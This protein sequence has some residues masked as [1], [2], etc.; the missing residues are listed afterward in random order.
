VFVAVTC[1]VPTSLLWLVSFTRLLV[2]AK[3]TP[4]NE[5]DRVRGVT[6]VAPWTVSGMGVNEPLEMLTHVVVPETLLEEAEQP[7]AN[8]REFHSKKELFL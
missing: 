7:V 4:L 2:N 5:S 6:N 8:P 3:V 1:I